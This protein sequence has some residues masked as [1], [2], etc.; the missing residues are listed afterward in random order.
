ME[1]AIHF[2]LPQS[3][4]HASNANPF[5][6]SRSEPLSTGEGILCHEI[7]HD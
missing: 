3:T 1:Q 4:R 5:L 7:N 2:A 6:Y